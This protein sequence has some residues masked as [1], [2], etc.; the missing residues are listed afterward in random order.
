MG[1]GWSVT[2][3]G[4][5]CEFLFLNL[6]CLCCVFWV[7]LFPMEH[8]V[9]HVFEN[10]LGNGW[11]SYG[12]KRSVSGGQWRGLWRF[13][14]SDLFRSSFWGLGTR[15]RTRVLSELLSDREIWEHYRGRVGDQQFNR[16][17]RFQLCT[18]TCKRTYLDPSIW[19][20]R[21]C[22]AKFLDRG[23]WFGPKSILLLQV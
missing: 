14:F 22:S 6:V 20:R 15:F 13:F 23:W 2:S 11:R 12:R 18:Y 10:R 8:R 21:C 5:G 17:W 7:C 4:R 1:G 3:G 19:G 9:Q 16:R